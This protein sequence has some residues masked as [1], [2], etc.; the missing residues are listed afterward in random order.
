[1]RALGICIGASTLTIVDL[2]RSD[3]DTEV[4]SLKRMQH[5]GNPKE[6]LKKILSA[7][8]LSAYYNIGITGRKFRSFVNAPSIS[9]S[10]AIEYALAHLSYYKEADSILSVGGETFV[11]YKI[12]RSGKIANVYSGNKCAAGT[13]DF[14]MQ[15]LT[16]L[17]LTVPE[18]MKIAE[19]KVPHRISGRCSVFC[20]SDCTHA[21]NKGYE[22]GEIVAGL[23][24][25]IARKMI[26]L[27]NK[28]HVKKLLVIGGVSNNKIAMDR[29]QKSITSLHVPKEAR[30]FEAL[31]VALWAIHHKE[32]YKVD[33]ATLLNEDTSTYEFLPRLTYY[34]DKVEFREIETTEVVKNDE[35]IVGLDV[36]S[37]TTKAVLLRVADDAI[38][39]SVYLRT[40][41]N[42]IEA[43]RS[44]Y[45]AIDESLNTGVRIIGLGTTGSGRQIAGLH[46]L[47]KC[48]V[49]EIIAHARA[50]VFFDPEVDTIF[51][52]GGQ[53]AKYTYLTNGVPSD[54]AM[55]EA[56]S[57]GTGSF[58]EESAKESL[59]I[60]VEEI[61]EI[62]LRA[63]EPPNFNDQ[64]AAFISSDIKNAMHENISRE[65]I[66]AGLVYSICMNYVNRV[67]GARPIGRKIFM[68]G[69]TCYNRAVPIAMAALTG[70]EIVV[71][72]EPGLMG[73]FG[74]ALV[75]KDRLRLQV[76]NEQTFDLTELAHRCVKNLNSF[77]CQGK[78]ENCDRKCNIRMLELEGKRYPF[79]GA[80]NKYFNTMYKK[81]VNTKCFNHIDERQRI[82]FSN[83]PSRNG[84][85]I[86][87]NRSFLTI[88]YYPLFH[89]FFSELGMQP[90]ISDKPDKDGINRKNASFCMPF[91]LS[92]GM[93]KQL[94]DMNPD[95]IFLPH[96]SQLPE[97]GVRHE[98]YTC[99][100]VQSECYVLQIAFKKEL[101]NK[102][103]LSPYISFNKGLRGARKT[104]IKL[105][106]E[107]GASEYKA[108]LAF[109]RAVSAQEEAEA[110]VRNI[111]SEAVKDIENSDSFGVVL[112]G[113]PYNAFVDEGNLA[114]PAKFASR[115]IHVVPFDGLPWEEEKPLPNVYWAMGQRNLRAAQYTY[116]HP[117]LFAVFI[118]NF[119]CGPDSFI[120]TH[121]R[122]I[123]KNKPYLI[124]E[125]DSLTADAG[126][127]T[128]IEAFLDVVNSYCELKQDVKRPKLQEQSKAP[129]VK[130]RGRRTIIEAS[131]KKYKLKDTHIII[132]SMGKLTSEALAAAGRGVGVKMTALPPAGTDELKLGRGNTTCK[133]CLP[134]ILITG[135]LL[136]YLSVRCDPK[137][138]TVLFLVSQID[139]CRL[140]HYP[141]FYE[142]LIRNENLK[143]LAIISLNDQDGYSGLGQRFRL[144]A[145]HGLLTADIMS[146]VHNA[147]L[148]LACDP[149][150]AITIF[151]DEWQ[152]IL[153]VLRKECGTSLAKQLSLTS[154]RLATIPLQKQ[155]QEAPTILLTGEIYVR[156][157]D[158]SRQYLVER[159]SKYGFVV[160]ETP[161]TEAV[162]Y[163]NF[164]ARNN[165][166]IRSTWYRLL[167]HLERRFFEWSERKLRRI[168][169]TSGLC[170][171][172]MIDVAGTLKTSEHLVGIQIKGETSL[173]VGTSLRE[174]LDHVSGII[175]IGPFG[176]M[177]SR[178]SE[179]VLTEEMTL[180]GK[181]KATGKKY[182]LD[183]NDLPFL[184]IESDAGTF[185]QITETRLEAFCLQVRRVHDSIRNTD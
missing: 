3:D 90:V 69:G 180:A 130:M 179:A 17:G 74:V 2:I 131:G 78:P 1:M 169:S 71:P 21:L 142:K 170:D 91:E 82:I 55:N 177:P 123:M 93:F 66:V 54:Y 152:K 47:T 14:F 67:K 140:C 146:D 161:A 107:L 92:H 185:P 166:E 113:R 111:S 97:P 139:P 43:S 101:A 40:N 35:C 27:I 48:I 171:E 75:V 145:W 73:A 20:K 141:G 7:Y 168:I 88:A 118:T 184:A 52:I 89:T 182:D 132:P 121:F 181:L 160:K 133:E 28:A 102:H 112:F 12:N 8:D 138:L 176:C 105:A 125:L 154:T 156:K 56:C 106:E 22:K 30:Y 13:G 61:A 26:E 87:L 9:E 53:D 94:L 70:K 128:R 50:A 51:E 4:L 149:Q 11:L 159:L 64:C 117:K 84:R 72:P 80:C 144:A 164:L 158:I 34:E 49:N 136:K 85:M 173:T 110:E 16:R 19:N 76:F 155:L 60:N 44:C 135:S 165:M 143:N 147:L 65:E 45:R 46:A 58:L 151:D 86:G 37:T 174:I 33:M 95:I 79:G 148:T 115:G 63:H 98:K 62:A 124:L 15:Q 32:S 104:F 162:L 96:I 41:G 59:G 114:I 5:E 167:S 29:V 42:P 83:R 183:V 178:V 6:K 122:D 99:V 24:E 36:G 129:I 38:L 134:L 172:R 18:A 163:T 103:V 175:S 23:C 10:E 157:D 116:R 68:Q 57:A 81:H 109:E 119:S 77:V 120:L 39:R 127:E 126:I 153:R 100:F 108:L 25:M 31:G 137:E 150:T